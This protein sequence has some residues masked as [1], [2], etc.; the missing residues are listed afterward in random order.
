M[1]KTRAELET[2]IRRAADEQSWDVFSEDPVVM[3]KL[4]RLY[5][6]GKKRGQGCVWTVPR[7]GLSFRRPRVL[8]DLER[9]TKAAEFAKRLNRRP[10]P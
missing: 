2:I 3:R 6:A 8:G 1:K 9:K 10:T 7:T 4:L 5:G